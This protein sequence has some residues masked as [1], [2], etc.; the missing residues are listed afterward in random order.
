M[1][2]ILLGIFV[3]AVAA[4]RITRHFELEKW[5]VSIGLLVLYTRA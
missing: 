2:V 3:L 1:T 4:M 5:Q